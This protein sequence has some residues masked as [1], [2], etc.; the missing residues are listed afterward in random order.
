M[1]LTNASSPW[2]RCKKGPQATRATLKS[3]DLIDQ[4]KK[5]EAERL[6][7]EAAQDDEAAG[8]ARTK[9]A[10]ERYR[11]IAATAGLADP[12][13]A[14]EYYAKA[15]KLDPDNINGM[16]WHGD[17]EK[18]SG[19]LG[20]AE[21]A[22]SA[23]LKSGVK[24][25]EDDDLL[26]ASLGLGDLDV[27]RGKLPEALKAYQE[28]AADADRLAKADPGNAGR[29]KGLGQRKGG[30]GDL[31]GRGGWPGPSLTKQVETSF[32][33]LPRPSPAMRAG[34]AISR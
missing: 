11:G 29:E 8:I 22:Y 6:Q 2:R 4:G 23:V 32:P 9:K 19:N 5:V 20:E 31:I 26:W 7:V 27:A 21:R 3:S 13:K 24:G 17:M 25:T 33:A 1:L 14:R 12:K 30:R 34:S 28:A 16:L 18:Q 10:A 15:A